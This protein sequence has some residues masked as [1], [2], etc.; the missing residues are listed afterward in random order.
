MP[1]LPEVEHVVCYLRGAISG[2]RLGGVAFVDRR[3]AK[4][5]RSLAALEGARV[6]TVRRRGKLILIETNGET[7]GET[8]G[9]ATLAFHLKMTGKVW[10]E[11]KERARSPW[12]R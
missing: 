6:E 4:G 2:R 3:S 5:V 7:K 11:P 9:R 8:N 12:T 10:V 1:E